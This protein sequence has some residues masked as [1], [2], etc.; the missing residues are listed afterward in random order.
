MLTCRR[1]TGLRVGN[2][3][4]GLRFLVGTDNFYFFIDK[5]P[6]WGSAQNA[7]RFLREFAEGEI[8]WGCGIRHSSSRGKLHA[9]LSTCR[10]GVGLRWA[11][12]YELY[13]GP[14]FCNSLW[15]EIRRCCTGR[16]RLQTLPHLLSRMLV[17]GFCVCVCVCLYVWVCVCVSLCV[18]VCMRA[19]VYVSVSVCVCVCVCLCVC[20]CVE[21]CIIRFASILCFVVFKILNHA[22]QRSVNLTCKLA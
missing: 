4:I 7:V 21:L 12:Q 5:W 16:D 13:E 18:C 17:H 3:R 1:L 20:V 9:F 22:A 6:V 2:N 14:L 10:H 19:C 11:A 8:A 15:P